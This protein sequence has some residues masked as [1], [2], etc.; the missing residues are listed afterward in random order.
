M[1]AV[2]AETK[3][4]CFFYVVDVKNSK[5]NKTSLWARYLA[6]NAV[7]RLKEGCGATIHCATHFFH[8]LRSDECLVIKSREWD[9]L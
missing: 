5:H 9:G 8:S 6:E 4:P 2:H 7:L 3:N 1:N